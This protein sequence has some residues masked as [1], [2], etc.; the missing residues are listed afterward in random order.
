MSNNPGRKVRV[1]SRR[2]NRAVP[3]SPHTEVLRIVD[4]RLSDARYR[5]KSIGDFRKSLR[6]L[7]DDDSF[8][9][10]LA[11]LR[12]AVSDLKTTMDELL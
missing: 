4:N 5:A 8:W 2:A 3:V 7:V 11:T 6:S 1:R 10:Q 12:K 9:K